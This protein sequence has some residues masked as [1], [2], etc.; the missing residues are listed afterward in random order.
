MPRAAAGV[1]RLEGD[2]LGPAAQIDFGHEIG[3]VILPVSYNRGFVDLDALV[4]VDGGLTNQFPTLTVKPN[5]RAKMITVFPSPRRYSTNSTKG[6][7]AL[8]IVM[9]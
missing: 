9:V 5:F 1:R 4:Q 6:E 3:A 2:L 8:G 7:V